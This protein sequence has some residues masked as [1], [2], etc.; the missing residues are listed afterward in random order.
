MMA[1]I[2]IIVDAQTHVVVE[3]LGIMG[4]FSQ[5]R[6]RCRPSSPGLAGGPGEGV[7][8]DGGRQRRA[9]GPARA[10]RRAADAREGRSVTP[11]PVHLRQAGVSLVVAPDPDGVPVLVHW[12]RTWAS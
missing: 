12:G 5:G 3:G 8:A 4:D 1:G 6:T 9:Q 7:R 11:A 2:E 10:G